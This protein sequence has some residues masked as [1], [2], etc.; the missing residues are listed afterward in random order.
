[1]KK[2]VEYTPPPDCYFCGGIHYGSGQK[3]PY[4][5][6]RCHRDTR[7]DAIGFSHKKCE[8]APLPVQPMAVIEVPLIRREKEEL[9]QI[10]E[11]LKEEL[12]WYVD[13]R[14]R[15]I[16]EAEKLPTVKEDAP[17]FPSPQSE[18]RNGAA[19]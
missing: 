4:E 6:Q 17:P 16:A 14:N 12:R 18:D 3:C 5:C 1:M 8:C 19:K 7:D 15:L 13:E 10:I 11:R 9:V 2:T